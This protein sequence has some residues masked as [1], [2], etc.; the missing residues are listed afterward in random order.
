MPEKIFISH[1]EDNFTR[2]RILGWQVI[3]SDNWRYNSTVFSLPSFSHTQKNLSSLFLFLFIYNFQQP[4]SLFSFLFLIYPSY[5]S[6]SLVDMWFSVFY[7]KFWEDFSLSFQIFIIMPY[8]S[9]ILLQGFHIDIHWA[10]W[11]CPISRRCFI[12]CSFF[13]LSFSLCHFYL[14][15]LKFINSFC[16]CVESTVYFTENINIIISSFLAFLLFSF[17]WFSTLCWSSSE[18]ACWPTFLLDTLTY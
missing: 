6:L 18:L 15:V 17:L 2:Y 8:S 7:N 9:L 4:E 10:I 12:F 13:S 16:S 11:Y 1:L 3:S 5:Y 14:S